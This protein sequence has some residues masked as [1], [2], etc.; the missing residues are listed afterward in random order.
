MGDSVILTVEASSASPVR[1]QWRKGGK[2]IAGATSSA[3][4][5]ADVKAADA[6]AYDVLVANELGESASAVVTL[7]VAVAA[8]PGWHSARVV[9]DVDGRLTYPA[10]AEG[11]RIVD[12]SHAGYR[13]GGVPL[14]QVPVVKTI[15]PV[16]GDNTAAIQAA[17]DA[18][19]ALPL[20]AD[21][22][23][24]TLLLTAGVYPVS[25]T[26]FVRHSGVV[27]A[28]VGDEL[29]PAT[30]TIIRRT[31]TAITPVIVVGGG[32][33]DGFRA[34]IA[35][36]RSNITTALVPLGARSFQVA[37]PA[38][39]A[40]GQAIIV[41][42]P[43]ND[44]WLASV[45]YGDTESLTEAWKPGEID[46]RYHRYITAIEGDTLTLDAPVFD[47]LDRALSQ[48]YVFRYNAAG[49]VTHAAVDRLFVDIES[50]G[51]FSEDHAQDAVSFIK[52]ENCWAREVQTRHFVEAGIKFGGTCT[53]STAERC[54]AV[55]PHSIVTGERR[56]NFCTYRAQ[57][58][59]FRQCYA[60]GARHAYVSNGASLDSG[61]VFLDSTD[62]ANLLT[63]EGHRRWPQALLYDNVVTRNPGHATS[64]GLYN[65][66][67]KGTGHGWS[68]AQS[69]A[70][71]ADAGGPTR[72][73]I[74]QKPPGAQNYAIG[75]FGTITGVF[76]NTSPA[77]F[78]EVANQAG[79]YPR[80]LYLAQVADRLD[81]PG[82]AAG[83]LV[84]RDGFG[85][86]ER[87][88]QA[89]PDS[90][91]WFCSS[92]AANLTV[93]AGAMTLTTNGGTSGRHAVAYFPRQTLA[94]GGKL[95]YRIAFR[96][97]A[98]L[99][100]FA[101]GLRFGLFDRT[102][103]DVT[104][105]GT[106]L[107]TG[108]GQNPS[109]TYPGYA[110]MVNVNPSASGALEL[111]RRVT[112]APSALVTATSAYPTALGGAPSS[113]QKMTAGPDYVGTLVLE[114]TTADTL[115]LTLSLSGGTLFA[116]SIARTDT[117]SPVLAFDTAMVSL[118]SGGGTAGAGAL[119]LDE[120][121][122]A[123]AVP[124]GFAGWRQ[125]LFTVEELADELISGP[126]SD[127]DGDGIALLAAYAFGAEDGRVP[128]ELRPALSVLGEGAGR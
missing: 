28:G 31:G 64:I 90:L 21:G 7:T 91:A 6:G 51:E 124:A 80:S 98:P 83:A 71:R 50:A 16:A 33:D 75:C 55:D 79:L 95:T 4:I 60:R 88:S 62:D 49:T 56:Y 85:D 108:D 78:I 11:N 105:A 5:L 114:R 1:Y 39:Y 17:L 127:V 45:N 69:V 19:G 66:T 58:V 53:R 103:G 48:S 10:D 118:Y 113:A 37:N 52:T 84:F 112:T 87:A 99:N 22:Y 32:T 42:Q 46:L 123:H 8:S 102:G 72:K 29:D 15:S 97:G 57:L 107:Y 89:P 119:I 93:G 35:G 94:V 40:V 68:A 13:G 20:Q 38:L 59:L 3:L 2:L 34:E 96:L 61:V 101:R 77:G 122:L 117:A 47:R 73:I 82:G 43:S 92:S 70:W 126:E 12:F 14:P 36:S 110:A 116:H 27:L 26:I 125:A 86:G 120:A 41:C 74:V 67:D 30:S 100:D 104:P 63:S 121:S 76:D 24:G 65:R 106:V 115:A 18:V 25:A 44:A 23:R 109:V 81:P 111:R 54:R 128:A 9:P